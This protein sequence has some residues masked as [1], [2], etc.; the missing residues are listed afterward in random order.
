MKRRFGGRCNSSRAD[1]A[2]GRAGAQ[3]LAL[4]SRSLIIVKLPDHDICVPIFGMGR[5]VAISRGIRI[6]VITTTH[7]HDLPR[8][9]AGSG[10]RS[11]Q[12]LG[13]VG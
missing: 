10:S 7:R 3:S 6:L 11:G 9:A 5:V 13:T 2:H 8:T 12:L 1:L 4:V